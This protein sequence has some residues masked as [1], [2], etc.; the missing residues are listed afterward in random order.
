MAI[1]LIRSFISF[2]SRF[3][4]I[5][6][7]V[8]MLKFR[9]WTTWSC[10]RKSRRRLLSKIFGKDTW[11]ITYLYP[12]SLGLSHTTREVTNGIATLNWQSVIQNI[13]RSFG[14]KNNKNRSH[15]VYTVDT[16]GK[17]K[18]K[19]SRTIRFLQWLY[20]MGIHYVKR[21]LPS[22][23]TTFVRDYTS[24]DIDL[25]YGDINCLWRTR[26]RKFNYSSA[27]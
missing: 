26:S 16:K 19:C 25:S 24:C 12:L 3:R 7:R 4:C 5:T 18:T 21:F 8:K 11:M 23:T 9:E 20:R 15:A 1:T 2:L 10:S 27:S 14:D 6:G 22:F 13:K 17:R